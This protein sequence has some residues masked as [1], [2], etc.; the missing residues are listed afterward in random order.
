MK[1]EMILYQFPLSHYCEKVR[2]ALDYK[3][4]PF[5]TRNLI[6]GPH[7]FVTKRLAPKTSV[8]ILIDGE[9]IIQ[10]STRIIDY[11]DE[12]YPEN[13]LTPRNEN[14]RKEALELEEY[15]DKNVGVQLRRFAY[16][17]LLEDKALVTSLLLQNAPRYKQPLYKL[18]FPLVKQLMKKSM[19]IYEKPTQKSL[20]ILEETL[21]QLNQRLKTNRFLI[22]DQFS[23]ADLTACALLGPLCSPPE[24][25]FEWPDF[26]K[27]PAAL[28]EFRKTHEADPFFGWVLKIYRNHRKN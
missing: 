15:F 21:H 1:M 8:P 27:M 25:D 12:K 17:Y 7:L 28:R 9:K 5:Q 2:W 18:F 14:L 10:D 11:L 20:Q 23:R 13:S 3:K 19:S 24:Y 26:E 16:F 22:G 6:P 4:I